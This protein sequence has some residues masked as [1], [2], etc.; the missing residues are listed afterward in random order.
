MISDK[1]E[2]Y[3]AVKYGQTFLHLSSKE[4]I[5]FY[6]EVYQRPNHKTA[7]NLKMMKRAKTQFY[8]KQTIW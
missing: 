3:W 4:K 6:I 2:N 8:N 7:A 5:L 1:L